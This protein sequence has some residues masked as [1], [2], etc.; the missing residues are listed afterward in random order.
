MYLSYAL[1]ALSAALFIAVAVMWFRDDNNENQP[2][3]PPSTPGANQAIHVKEALEAE[4]LSV[5]FAPSGG[6][7]NELSVAGQLLEVDGAHLYAFIYPQGIAQREE[8][9]SGIDPAD[10]VIVNTRGTPVASEPPRVFIG[11]NV[12]TVMYGGD[13]ELAG[14]VQRAIE[15]LP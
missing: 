3:P 13:D 5:S 14:K 10:M 6:R 15:G 2:P 7:S 4:G 12:V 11:S 9:T 1:F 8:D